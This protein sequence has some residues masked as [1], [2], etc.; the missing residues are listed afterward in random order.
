LIA[1]TPNAASFDLQCENVI[2]PTTAAT[3]MEAF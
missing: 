1:V 3:S 2:V